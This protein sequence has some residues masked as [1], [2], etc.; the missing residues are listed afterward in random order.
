M[1]AKCEEVITYDLASRMID[2][3]VDLAPELTKTSRSSAS[4]SA[5]FQA[6]HV[7]TTR[8]ALKEF[9]TADI[10]PCQPQ[11]G[12][13][14]FRMKKLSGLDFETRSPKFS[15]KH[16]EGKT[17]E[18]ILA[19]VENKV[20]QMIGNYTHREWQCAQKILKHQGRVNRVLEEMNVSCPPRQRP[21]TASKKMQPAGNI[22]SEPAEISTKGKVN[23]SVAAAEGTSKNVKATDVLAQ[24]KAKAAKTTL[25]PTAEKSTKL[26]KFSENLIRR[27]TDEAKVDAE[28]REKKKV[29]YVSPVITFK[30]KT[31]SKRKAPIV[32]EKDKGII[33][34][35]SQPE[36]TRPQEKK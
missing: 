12:S 5:Y 13:W 25:P 15:V 27:K 18:E 24:R 19:G 30:K 16:L 34:E 35:D 3:D 22:G 28:E 7:I 4:T 21:V 36:S 26:M 29:Q 31:V 8:D 6:T 11:W 10:W 2:L 1:D 9:V 23:K 17:D 33:I 14:A 20:I 32:S